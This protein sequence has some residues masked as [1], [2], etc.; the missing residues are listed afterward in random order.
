MQT[1]PV[2][3]DNSIPNHPKP[4][5]YPYLIVNNQWTRGMSWVAMK[6]V[7]EKSAD[8]AKNW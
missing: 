6:S 1:T 2:I 5:E 8:N 4:N 3:M 7:S